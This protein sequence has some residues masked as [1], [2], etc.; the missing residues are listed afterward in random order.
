MLVAGDIR[1]CY[2]TDTGVYDASTGARADTPSGKRRLATATLRLEG[3][4]WKME[5]L[6]DEG[7]GC[8]AA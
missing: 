6:A 3:G 1:D 7:L 4:T 2:G 5:R 8:T